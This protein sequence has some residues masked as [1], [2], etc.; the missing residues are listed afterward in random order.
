M[1]IIH[2]KKLVSNTLTKYITKRA[3]PG[4]DELEVHR[5]IH[6]RD[7]KL[8]VLREFLPNFDAKIWMVPNLMISAKGQVEIPADVSN[9]HFFQSDEC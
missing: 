2:A 7:S 3:L 9:A 5:R 4:S 6:E 8:V 1:I